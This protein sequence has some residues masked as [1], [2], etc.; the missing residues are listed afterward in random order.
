MMEGARIGLET[1]VLKQDVDSTNLAAE[2]SWPT[3]STVGWRR[4]GERS[5]PPSTSASDSGRQK[6][7]TLVGFPQPIG[8]WR[9]AAEG[10][11]AA[12]LVG[13][14]E[15]QR[16]QLRQ[17]FGRRKLPRRKHAAPDTG[18]GGANRATPNQESI[19]DDDDHP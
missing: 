16:Q 8:R 7:S 19:D 6:L 10:P 1:T 11:L 14:R 12:D 2:G 4:I 15:C 17:G 3:V 9:S 5:S 18:T 13:A